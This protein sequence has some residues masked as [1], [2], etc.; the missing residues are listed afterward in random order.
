VSAYPPRAFPGVDTIVIR[1]IADVFRLKDRECD[2]A[3]LPTFSHAL[4]RRQHT[5]SIAIRA[6]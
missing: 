3:I 4:A 5:L 2:N 1:D 6:G